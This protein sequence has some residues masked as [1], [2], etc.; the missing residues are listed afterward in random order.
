MPEVAPET[1]EPVPAPPEPE[2]SRVSVVAV[3]DLLPHRAVKATGAKL[4]WDLVF[5]DIQPLVEEADIAFANLEGPVAPVAHTGTHGEVFNAPAE[6]LDG[7]KAAGFDVLS[8]ANNHAYDQGVAG[9]TETVTNVETRGML[10]V[11]AGR[12]CEAAMAAQ[13]VEHDG[14][15][16]AFL[17][18][19]DLTNIDENGEPTDACVFWAGDECEGEDCGPDRDAIHFRP[20]LKRLTSAIEAAAARSDF[21]VL[22]FHWGNEYRTEP[23][24]EYPKLAPKLIEAGADV[25]LGH[26]PHVLQPIARIGDGLVIYSLGNFVSNMAAN[27]DPETSSVGRGNTRDGAMLRFTLVKNPDGSR[28]IEDVSAI[29]LWT[30]ND[31]E[32]PEVR[33]TTHE[34]LEG[35]LLEIRAKA[36]GDILGDYV[37][38]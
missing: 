36:V 8:L 1:P 35:K 2:P 12:S 37:I 34:N 26:H 23:L 5:K 4:G 13:I 17:A 22:S 6:L 30:L 19:A 32:K 18:T 16:V 27:Y 38:Q 25:I 29:P 7:V 3:G 9:L 20:D 14:V 33:V 15:K 21:V 11:G 31:A 28:I 24:P 10:P